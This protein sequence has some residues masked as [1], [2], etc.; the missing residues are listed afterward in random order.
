MSQGEEYKKICPY[1][2]KTYTA[3]HLSRKYCSETCKRRMFRK[4][5][6]NKR[7][8]KNEDREALEL[9]DLRLDEL[10]SK[11]QPVFIKSEIEAAGFNFA[12]YYRRYKIEN[13]IV[14]VVK[15]YLL[16]ELPEGKYKIYPNF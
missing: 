10:F 9:N 2:G 12:C 14:Y 13:Y 15:D 4:N 11:K 5:Q 6:Q 16:L 8:R 3:K 1:D 7:V